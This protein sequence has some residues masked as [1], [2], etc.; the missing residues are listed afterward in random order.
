MPRKPAKKLPKRLKERKNRAINQLKTIIK[1]RTAENKLAVKDMGLVKKIV[2]NVDGIDQY[3]KDLDQN[4]MTT[5]KTLRKLY[6]DRT[7]RLNRRIDDW[8]D[9][10]IHD[11]DVMP[12]IPGSKRYKP[13]KPTSLADIEKNAPPKFSEKK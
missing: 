13:A 1:D 3:D 11:L 6:Q 8:E 10:Q 2:K 4:I 12:T 5:E 7:K 9:E